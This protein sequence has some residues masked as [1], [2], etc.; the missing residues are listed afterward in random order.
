MASPGSRLPGCGFPENC[1]Q[2]INLEECLES[3]LN[4][5]VLIISDTHRMDDRVLRVMEQEAPVDM[6]IHAGDAEGSEDYFEAIA[7][8]PSLYVSG[9]ND[10]SSLAP[11]TL[12]FPIGSRKA[13]LTHG[14]LYQVSRSTA[15][16]EAEA[17][18]RGCQIAIYGHT[19]YPE[20]HRTEGGLLVMNP[21]SLAYP[22]QQGYRPSYIV[23]TINDKD[24]V[25]AE[26]RYLKR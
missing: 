6:I 5:K 25:S 9:N 19:H 14:H 26:I 18:K 10:Y 21:G 20:M 13:L 8:M 16:L 12:V 4:M 1:L 3:L 2:K 7:G 22:R 15:I 24:E 11:R 23:L 17:E